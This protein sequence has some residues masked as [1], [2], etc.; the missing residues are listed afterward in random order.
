MLESNPGVIKFHCIEN[1]QEIKDK[2]LRPGSTGSGR[3][4]GQNLLID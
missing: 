3:V 1:L 4:T 2:A